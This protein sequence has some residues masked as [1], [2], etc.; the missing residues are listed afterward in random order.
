MCK[1]QK[2]RMLG[3]SQNFIC[4]EKKINHVAQSFTLS[5]SRYLPIVF[6]ILVKY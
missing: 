6:H 4:H 1:Y 5:L 2:V 3:A